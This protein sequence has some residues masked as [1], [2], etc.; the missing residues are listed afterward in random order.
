M[1]GEVPVRLLIVEDDDAIA[2][3]LVRAVQREGYDV[4]SVTTPSPW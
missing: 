2:A 4:E 3:P 1:L